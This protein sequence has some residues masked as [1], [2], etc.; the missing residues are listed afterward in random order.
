MRI[1]RDHTYVD[2][3]DRGAS[4]AIGNFDGVHLGHLSVIEQA[5]RAG[6]AIGAPLGILT[7][8]PHPREYFAPEAPP[9]RLM[10][11]EARAHRLEKLG[12]ERLYEINFNAGSPRSA[13]GTSSRR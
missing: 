8:E 13:R 10:N 11:R 7:F 2:D 4:V 6:A 12:V 9:F 1:I 5:R 3:A